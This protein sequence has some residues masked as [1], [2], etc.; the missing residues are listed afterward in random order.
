MMAIDDPTVVSANN[1][2]NPDLG[3]VEVKGVT[4]GKADIIVKDTVG[5][6]GDSGP[7]GTTA[8]GVTGTGPDVQ[9]MT[10]NSSSSQ[11]PGF[12][13]VIVPS[14][15]PVTINYSTGGSTLPNDLMG[16]IAGGSVMVPAGDTTKFVPE[17]VPRW[18]W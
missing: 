18:R 6:I 9:G 16:P 5:D 14:I 7:Y 2:D 17:Q 1:P 10:Y 3:Y 12:K 15:T 4:L 11:I 13:F 8:P